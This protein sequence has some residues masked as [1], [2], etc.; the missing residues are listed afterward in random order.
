[1]SIPRLLELEYRRILRQFGNIYYSSIV[2]SDLYLLP[3]SDLRRANFCEYQLYLEMCGQRLKRSS[4]L[5]LGSAVHAEKNENRKAV[6]KPLITEKRLDELEKSKLSRK[7]CA[8]MCVSELSDLKALGFSAAYIN[9]ALRGQSEDIA[10]ERRVENEEKL[11]MVNR[12]A[13]SP[14]LVH[15]DGELE[16]LSLTYSIIGRLDEIRFEPE[17]VVILDDKPRPKRGDV[18]YGDRNQVVAYCIAFKDMMSLV[19][20]VRPIYAAVR[21]RSSE[22]IMWEEELTETLRLGVCNEIEHLRSLLQSRKA[23]AFSSSESEAKCYWCKLNCD[24]RL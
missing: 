15:I 11:S 5:T 8:D 19:G 17:R 23:D 2:D 13:K 22:D 16:L 9:E 21:D 6:A 14:S 12:L 24:R 4:E 7:E 3:I 1:M 10:F 18:Y 20:D